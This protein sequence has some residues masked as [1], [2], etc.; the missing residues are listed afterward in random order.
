[1]KKFGFIFLMVMMAMLA[2]CSSDDDNASKKDEEGALKV[3]KGLLNVEVTLPA[4]F[5]E[6]EDIDSVIAEAKKDGV[7]KVTKNE[8]GSLMYKMPKS[9]HKEMMKD[10]EKN[11]E[12]TMEEMKNGKDYPSIKEVSHNK[13]FSKFTLEVDK[14]TYENGFD[15]FA[16]MG[17]GITG[18]YYQVFNGASPDEYKVTIS[19]K[20]AATQ[21]VFD[22]VVY[23]DD[24]EG[25][26]E[27]K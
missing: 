18:M 26:E 8:D 3:D 25:E 21:K 6:G 14:E 5:F 1:M 24:L 10:L 7:S 13:A 4:S 16:A 15:G 17:L 27:A 12:E 2:A 22:E 11:A 19:V 23:P 9:K 20:D